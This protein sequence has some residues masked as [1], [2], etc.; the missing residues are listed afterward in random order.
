VLQVG[1]LWSPGLLDD[2]DSVYL[3]VAREMLGR[4]DFVTPMVDG[5]RFFDKPP[6]M[7]WMAAGSMRV[8]GVH[9]WAARLPLALG[10]LALLFAV[11]AL[12]MRLF[13]ER[14]G[15]YAALVLATSIGPYLYTRFYIPDIL[16][17][18]WMT[19][20][21][22]LFLVALERVE[23][24]RSALWASVGFGAVMALNVLTK[25]IIGAV[26]PL[27]FV[28]GY[29]AWTRRLGALRKMHLAAATGMFLLIAAPWHV[30]AALRN[31]AIAMP[32]GQGLP[33]KA[34]WAWFYLYNEHIGRFLGLR[35]PHDYGQTPVW[36]FWVYALIW[37][38]PWG[39]FLPGAVAA[40]RRGFK[41]ER[42]AALTVTLWTLLVMVFFTVSSRQEYYSL[43]ALPA[44]ALMAGGFLARAESGDALALRAA[45][46]CHLW[47]LVPVASVLALVCGY[48]A[49]VTRRPA[50]GATLDAMLSSHPALYNV[51]LGHVFDLTT[52]ALGFFR[53]PLVAVAVGMVVLGPVAYVLRCRGRAFTSNLLIAGGM[54]VVLLAAHEGLVRFYPILG[55]KQLAQAIEAARQPGDVVMID[56]ELTAGSTL[57]FYE[58]GTEP[59]LL[60]DGR[61]NG[62]WFGGFWPDAPQIFA[63]EAR[64]DQL[65][66]GP[67]RVFLLTYHPVVR[68][69]DLRQFGP[70]IHVA[71]A[72]GKTVLSNR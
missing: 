69:D 54:V 70:V 51:S 17:A 63:D 65:W 26:F 12:G 61:M 2:V 55:S 3:Q 21:V 46:A 18:L 4:H 27:G 1:G 23:G 31:P 59:V 14:G 33:A 43:P 41:T 29:L 48:F 9:E 22:H 64:L 7:Y 19:L 35:V 38:M 5:V 28:V 49:A 24:R 20:S 57:L 15:L 66:S 50:D 16:I 53:G 6:L 13:G 56:G 11:Y 37:V 47:L 45:R 60:V 36:L 39:A 71:A 10:V 68:T 52:Q 25:G 34:G 40:V 32:V 58:K 67:K 42:E 62:P 8:F 44:L 30:L 72:G